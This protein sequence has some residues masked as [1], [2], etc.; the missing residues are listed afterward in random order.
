MG[1]STSECAANEYIDDRVPSTWH[2][3]YTVKQKQQ[4]EV[5]LVRGINV[6][7]WSSGWCLQSHN[8]EVAGSGTAML[9]GACAEL[10]YYCSSER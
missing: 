3:L 5:Q 6:Q 1:S 7:S 2:K 8:L 9:E 4:G 10:G